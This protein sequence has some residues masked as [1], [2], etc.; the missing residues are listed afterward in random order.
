[1]GKD[2]VDRP[3]V[4]PALF[5]VAGRIAPSSFHV[6]HQ[7]YRGF[8]LGPLAWPPPTTLGCFTLGHQ[9]FLSRLSARL[10]SARFRV[11]VRWDLP[12]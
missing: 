6:A 5:R 2:G 1:V 3:A 7:D 4:A 10:K 9:G 11:E 8:A 12:Y